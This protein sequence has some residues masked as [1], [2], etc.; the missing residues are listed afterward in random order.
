M[1][2]LLGLVRI[3]FE[4]MRVLLEL[5]RI[6][7]ELMRVLFELIRLQKRSLPSKT[8]PHTGIYSH[9]PVFWVLSLR[10]QHFQSPLAT[11]NFPVS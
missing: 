2:V 1:R 4:L 8:L 9:V 7:L 6:L 11:I 3:L 10:L 5:M